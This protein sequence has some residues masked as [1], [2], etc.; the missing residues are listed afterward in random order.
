MTMVIQVTL[1]TIFEFNLRHMKIALTLSGGGYRGIAHVG[2]LKALEEAG[3]KPEAISGTSAG[4]V[5]GALYANGMSTGDML[6]FFK[7]DFVLRTKIR[8][9]FKFLNLLF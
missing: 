5:V 4:A 9:L 8:T 6:N 1:L 3:I 7:N 2:V